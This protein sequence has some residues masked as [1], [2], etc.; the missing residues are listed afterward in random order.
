MVET[1]AVDGTDWLTGPAIAVRGRDLVTVERVR[2]I[3]WPIP[4]QALRA[5]GLANLSPGERV[6]M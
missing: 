5:V 6:C 1:G 2:F 3:K 4:K